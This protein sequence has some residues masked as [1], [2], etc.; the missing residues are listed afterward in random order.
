MPTYHST[1]SGFAALTTVLILG[2]VVV[3]LILTVSL[4]S[5]GDAQQAL[6]GSQG[7]DA[8]NQLKGCTEV[9]LLELNESSTLPATVTT[10]DGS[11]TITLN[12]QT[13]TTWVFTTTGTFGSFTKSV[14]MTAERTTTIS[15]TS[16]KEVP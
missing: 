11:C 7:A 12:S 6:A 9:A 5:I 8:L 3:L 10:P 14:T 1:Q 13:G 15:I 4:S 16:W 2:A